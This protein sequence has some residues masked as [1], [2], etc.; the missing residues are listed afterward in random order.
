MNPLSVLPVDSHHHESVEMG[1]MVGVCWHKEQKIH[2]KTPV[3]NGIFSDAD[4][5]M[6]WFFLLDLFS[7]YTNKYTMIL[8]AIP[9][10]IGSI[11]N[12]YLLKQKY[13]PSFTQ[14]NTFES[15]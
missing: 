10:S 9:H 12:V 2:T 11:W 14:F 7:T 15:I 6:C 8:V 13:T 1:G 5:G 3:N 4:S